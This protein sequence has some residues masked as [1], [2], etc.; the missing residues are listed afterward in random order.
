MTSSAEVTSYDS[1]CYASREWSAFRQLGC[2]GL[3]PVNTQLR[4]P[5]VRS[6]SVD[7]LRPRQRVDDPLS[8]D[9]EETDEDCVS[10]S[11]RIADDDRVANVSVRFP[12]SSFA[13]ELVRKL[14]AVQRSRRRRLA[15]S[16]SPAPHPSSL[17]QRRTRFDALPD[18]LLRRVFAS[19]LDSCELCR[20]R[21]VC[22]RWNVVVWNDARLWTRVE[23]AGRAAL[24]VDAALR[25]LTRALSRTTPRVCVGV[26]TVLVGDCRRL[27]DDGLRTVAR[28][29]PDL[30]RL[31]V[32]SCSLV[33]DTAVLDVLSRCVNLQRLDVAGPHF[34]L[35]DF[36]APFSRDILG[37]RA[38]ATSMTSVCLSVR[39]YVTFVEYERM[40]QK[41]KIGT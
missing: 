1:R 10:S 41:V 39:L 31:D 13:A 3:C 4:P 29:C 30:R 15:S 7:A 11:D 18:A 19:G 38:Y 21:L 24:D 8:D 16:T 27:S 33:T 25:A 23:L 22:R 36:S 37:C 9:D 40:V 34:S 17:G 35:V 28:R 6:V 14:R 20:C 32:S 2:A 12:C 26:E 5:A